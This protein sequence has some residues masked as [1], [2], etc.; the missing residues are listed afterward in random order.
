MTGV[1][2][3]YEPPENPDLRLDGT[4]DVVVSAETLARAVLGEA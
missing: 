2:Q 3:D 1:G 4:D